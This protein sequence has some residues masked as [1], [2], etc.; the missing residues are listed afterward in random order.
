MAIENLTHT[1]SHFYQ[2][3]LNTAPTYFHFPPTGKRK[4]EDK[5]DISR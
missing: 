4:S 5:Y 3:N 1:N 2:M